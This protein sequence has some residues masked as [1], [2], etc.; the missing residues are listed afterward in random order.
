M[1]HALELVLLA[2]FSVSWWGATDVP[3]KVLSP[4]SGF[5]VSFSLVPH[6]S[7]QH[8]YFQNLK[9]CHIVKL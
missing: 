1:E 5:A 6:F 7:P 9:G 2:E 3:L 4:L 8:L